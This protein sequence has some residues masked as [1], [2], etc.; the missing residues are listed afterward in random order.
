V[1]LRL[2]FAGLIALGLSATLP[3]APPVAPAPQPKPATK[4]DRVAEL[5]EKLNAPVE[6]PIQPNGMTVKEYLAKLAKAHGAEIVLDEEMFRAAG[7][8][9]PAETKLSFQ[10]PS[11][12]R[13]HSLLKRVCFALGPGEGTPPPHMRTRGVGRVAGGADGQFPVRNH[14]G[15]GRPARRARGGGEEAAQEEKEVALTVRVCRFSGLHR[16]F[17]QSG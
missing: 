15:E 17:I 2:A 6:D 11:G 1:R 8:L 7:V 5:V 10:A 3:G 14:P 12:I 9:T 4:R 16:A 13:F